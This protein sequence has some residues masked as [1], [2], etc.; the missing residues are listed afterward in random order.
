MLA[1]NWNAAIK[2]SR[3]SFIIGQ[4]HA[5]YLLVL[6]IIINRTRTFVMPAVII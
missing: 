6:V 1:F 4:I 5:S 2:S 3:G